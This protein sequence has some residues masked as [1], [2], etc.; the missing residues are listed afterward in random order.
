MLQ[1][2]PSRLRAFS[3]IEKFSTVSEK[4]PAEYLILHLSEYFDEMT[5][6][7]MKHDGV[8]DKYIGDSVMAIWGAPNPDENQ[9]INACNAALGCQK[10][11]E[12]LK[13]KWAPLGKPPLPTRIGIHTGQAIVGNIGSQDRMN[14]T[15][16]GDSVNIASRLEGANKYYGTKILVSENV[17]AIARGRILF[18][19]I[20]KIAVKGRSSGIVVYEPLCSMKDADDKNYYKLID[21]CAKAKEAFELYQNQEFEEALKHYRSMELLFPGLE[22]S[23]EPL[24][25]KCEEFKQ[26]PPVDWDGTNHLTGK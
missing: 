16:I 3:D 20:D 10:I 24:I 11:L 26:T 4:L 6:E 7:I 13:E 15:A 23:L 14:F 8:I 17:E 25:K 22:L 12:E 5:K 2:A 1:R 9:V 21:L 18:R 19:V